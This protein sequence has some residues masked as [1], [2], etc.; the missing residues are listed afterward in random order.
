MSN[1]LTVQ[2]LGDA[3]K[4]RVRKAMMDAIPDEVLQGLIKK[5]FENFFEDGK[6]NYHNS[7][8]EPSSFKKIVKA[9]IELA[10]AERIKI[11][12]K[13]QVDTCIAQWGVT[14][15]TAVGKLVEEMAPAAMKGI[16]QNIAGTCISQLQRGY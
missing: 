11:L 14:G 8:I 7:F 9:Q 3:V 12:V 15:Q 1:E 5:E 16:M 13:E 6:P 2:S 10:M 4:D